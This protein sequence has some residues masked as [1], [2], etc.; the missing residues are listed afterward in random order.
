MGSISSAID[1]NLTL[2]CK[3]SMAKPMGMILLAIDV[4][5]DISL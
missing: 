2:A 3:L 1:V 4:N 5:R